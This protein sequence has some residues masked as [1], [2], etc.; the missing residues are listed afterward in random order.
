M[1]K[2]SRVCAEINL[3]AVLHNFQAMRSKLKGSTQMIAVVKTDGYGHGA[4]P[5]AEVLEPLDYIWGFAVA[6]AEESHIL[7]EAGVKKPILILGFVFPEDYGQLVRE[8]IRPT[9]F[10]Y[11]MA[12]QLSEEAEA[13]KAVL[14]IHLALDTGMTRIGFADTEESIQI[15]K[16]ICQ[17]PGIRIE[18][19]F[20]HF[21]RADERD[22]SHARAQS[23]RYI[24]FSERLAQEGVEIPF[25]HCANSASI[26]ELPEVQMELVRP[27]ITNYGIYPSDEMDREGIALQP[28]MSLKSHIVYIKE[29][30]AG[31]PVSYG[32]TFLTTK[33]TR[34]ATIPVGY[35]DGYPRSL[36][37]KG[38][39]L[40][41]GKRAPILGRVCMDQFMVDVTDIPE[42][43]EFD[44]V[45]LMGKSGSDEITVDEL[46]HL[47]G[48]FPY[49]FVCCIGKRVPRVYLRRGTSESAQHT[50]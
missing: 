49:E 11:E 44:E 38:Q 22:K 15:I 25:H 6:T 30:A 19:M 43:E 5:L 13:A 42:A 50:V 46:G 35:G 10:K 27:G 33:R 12:R 31:V 18:G 16:K 4:V 2:H 48:R 28:V 24:R 14:P 29:V 21:A 3:D 17:L 32:G 34:I 37:N 26:L 40:I 23:L 45:V 7:R 20:T 47:S 36:S 9:V 41:R 1:K 39:V 8:Q